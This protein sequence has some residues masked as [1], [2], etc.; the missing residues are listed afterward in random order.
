MKTRI[1]ES[2]AK[3]QAEWRNNRRLRMAGL[4]ALVVLSVHAMVTLETKRRAL[5]QSYTSDLE[6]QARLQQVSRQ[7]QWVVRAKE[8]EAALQ[9]LQAR[10]PQVSGSGLAQAELQTWLTGLAGSTG[11]SEPRVRVEDTLDVPDH[12]DMWQVLARL[13]G[14]RPAFGHEKFLRAVAQDMPWI[15]VER[16]EIAE[17]TPARVGMTV[18]S[19]YR[20][21]PVAPVAPVAPAA[22]DAAT[23]PVSPPVSEDAAEL[24]VP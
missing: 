7:T 15:Q 19:Y 21:S 10:I 4:V 17:G 22:A 3:I 14:Q 2:W 13:D 23:P 9:A 11:I 16:L 6:L 5:V 8:A 24:T 1:R 12:P 20:R 18:R